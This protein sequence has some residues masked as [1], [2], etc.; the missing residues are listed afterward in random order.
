MSLHLVKNNNKIYS[1]GYS[2]TIDVSA[3]AL[4]RQVKFYHIKLGKPLL[5][6]PSFVYMGTIMLTQGFPQTVDTKLEATV[7]VDRVSIQCS[8]ATVL[9]SRMLFTSLRG[10]CYLLNNCRCCRQML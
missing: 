9:K 3:R 6:G 8:P 10:F 4:C 1:C 7:Y 2:I 5:Y